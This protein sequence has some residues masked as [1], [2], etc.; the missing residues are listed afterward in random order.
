MDAERVLVHRGHS[1]VILLALALAL[2]PISCVESAFE[3][4]SFADGPGIGLFSPD[5]GSLGVL[6]GIVVVACL[7]ARHAWRQVRG[8]S[9][10]RMAK[11]L[12]LAL[13]VAFV[14]LNGPCALF[15]ASWSYRC[16][17]GEARACSAAGDLYAHG[18]GVRADVVRAAALYRSGC[19]EG[20]PIAC[21]RVLERGKDESACLRL[22][23]QCH[24]AAIVEY[25]RTFACELQ[26]KDCR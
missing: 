6:Y 24:S 26:A 14:G 8:G 9:D 15:A 12:A 25:D 16:E 5:P 23:E 21:H 4:G 1:H 2:C 3:F 18:Q 22:A 17:R 7:L 20:Y 13:C 19:D 11:L 10:R